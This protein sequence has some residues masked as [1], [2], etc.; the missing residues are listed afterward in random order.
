MKL[1]NRSG[2]RGLRVPAA[3]AA[4]ALA[5]VAGAP[6]TAS[7]Q[8]GNFHVGPRVTWNFDFEEVAIG[9]HAGIPLGRRLDFYPSID[10]FLPEDGS[11]LGL[12]ADFK[13]RPA[14]DVRSLYLGSGINFTRFS[15]DGRSNSE[16][17]LNLIAGFEAQTGVIHPFIEFRAIIGDE[18]ST[19]LTGGL[20][21]TL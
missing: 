12:N 1:A 11:L 16:T 8:T 13:F 15:N 7:G 9:G 19:Q 18:T 2:W 17:G 20:N 4:V 3:I 10:I 14:I 6:A 5:A 21:I